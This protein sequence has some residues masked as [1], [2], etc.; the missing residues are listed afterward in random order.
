[1][2]KMEK[3]PDGFREDEAA[4]RQRRRQQQMEEDPDGFR[5]DEAAGRQ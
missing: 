2:V 4:G 3:D 1:M 5:E